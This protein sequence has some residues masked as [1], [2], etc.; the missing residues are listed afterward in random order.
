[1]TMKAVTVSINDDNV[2]CKQ[3]LSDSSEARY[4]QGKG[5]SQSRRLVTVLTSAPHADVNCMLPREAAHL[6]HQHHCWGFAEQQGHA[7]D[8]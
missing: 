7:A 1:M 6:E 4:V 5:S 3:P 8:V 2:C